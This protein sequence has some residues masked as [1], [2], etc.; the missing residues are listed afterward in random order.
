[1]MKKS[2]ASLSCPT[3]QTLERELREKTSKTVRKA[4]SFDLD[5]INQTIVEVGE[6][7]AANT[8]TR[9]EGCERADGAPR[10]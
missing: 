2:P 5:G 1:M 6:E 7:V 4:I 10:N 3:G 9:A 8:F